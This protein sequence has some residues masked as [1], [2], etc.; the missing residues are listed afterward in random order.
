[1]H[2]FTILAHLGRSLKN[3]LSSPVKLDHH[4]IQVTVMADETPRP[5]LK[6]ITHTY[7]NGFL[8]YAKVH[9]AAH[10]LT[11]IAFGKGFFNTPDA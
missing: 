6:G 9:G 5:V 1:M 7:G 2:H 10:F 3:I 4:C 8:P 11:D